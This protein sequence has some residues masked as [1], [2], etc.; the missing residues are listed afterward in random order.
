[1]EIHLYVSENVLEILSRKQALV[2]LGFAR[3]FARG[4][5]SGEASPCRGE[6]LLEDAGSWQDV[7]RGAPGQVTATTL[8]SSPSLLATVSSESVHTRHYAKCFLVPLRPDH[9]PGSWA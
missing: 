9:V 3:A 1:M 4:T 6:R 8:L 7:E 2:C 5:V